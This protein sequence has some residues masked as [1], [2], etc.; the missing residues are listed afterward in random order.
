MQRKVIGIIVLW[1]FDLKGVTNESEIGYNFA[2]RS[3]AKMLKVS[4]YALSTP[5]TVLKLCCDLQA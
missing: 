2:I 1:C 5:Q 4:R 3:N